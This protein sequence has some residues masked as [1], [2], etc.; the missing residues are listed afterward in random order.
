MSAGI[1]SFSLPFRILCIRARLDERL[2]SIE[3][4]YPSNFGPYWLRGAHSAFASMLL[5]SRTWPGSNSFLRDVQ[6]E[7]QLVFDKYI[8]LDCQWTEQICFAA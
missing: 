1:S 5:E 7:V 3:L 4:G 6:N 8:V 2:T